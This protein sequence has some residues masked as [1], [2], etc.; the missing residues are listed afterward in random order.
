M[1]KLSFFFVAFLTTLSSVIY[2]QKA[3]QDGNNYIN[4][5][6]GFAGIVWK[7][8]SYGASYEHGFSDQFGGGAHLAYSEYKKGGYTYKALEFGVKGSYHFKA[9]D[10]VD[11][12]AGAEL[13]YISISHT[14]NNENSSPHSYTPVGIGLYGGVR[15]Y[16][17]PTVGVYG[18]LHLSTFSIVGLGVCVKL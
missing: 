7:G 10:N 18:E 16:F 14:G 6:V 1:K 8:V 9:T 11:P 4:A 15:Y 2:G 13:G 17:S 5:G 12:Y 3:F